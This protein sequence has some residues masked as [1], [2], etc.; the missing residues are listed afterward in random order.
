ML[1]LLGGGTTIVCDRYSH[2]G[3]AYTVAKGV[4]HLN[5]EYCKSLEVLLPAPDLVVNMTIAAEAT[6]A[7]GGY[8]A[9]RYE[10]VEFQHKVGW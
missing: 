5:L 2:S 7:R 1:R 10:K 9:E 4:P 8:G 6:A 3:V